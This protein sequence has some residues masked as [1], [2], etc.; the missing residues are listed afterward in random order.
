MPDAAVMCVTGPLLA[1]LASLATAYNSRQPLRRGYRNQPFADS[2]GETALSEPVSSVS[3]GCAA[4]SSGPRTGNMLSFALRQLT[5]VSVSQSSLSA[6]SFPLT[7][8]V[9]RAN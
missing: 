3:P 6:A 2:S 5:R 8:Y 4:S 1:R 9:N 7:V